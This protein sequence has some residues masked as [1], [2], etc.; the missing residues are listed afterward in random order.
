MN[1]TGWTSEFVVLPDGSALVIAD[2]RPC[3]KCDRA[4]VVVKTDTGL[5]YQCPE[6]TCVT[7]AANHRVLGHLDPD[8]GAIYRIRPD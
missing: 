6:T 8:T 3:R 2:I 7:R 5:K 4:M 1:P